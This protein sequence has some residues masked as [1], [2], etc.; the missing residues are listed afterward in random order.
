MRCI[1]ADRQYPTY[2][3]YKRLAGQFLP[4]ETVWVLLWAS[5]RG[6]MTQ[7]ATEV[8]VPPK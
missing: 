5:I 4:Q 8:F 7:D 2:R 6:T 3:R 1:G